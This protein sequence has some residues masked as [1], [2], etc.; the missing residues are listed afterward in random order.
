MAAKQDQVR[1]PNT[2]HGDRTAPN[3]KTR[4]ENQRVARTRRQRGYNWEDT[5]VKRFN[6]VKGWKAFRL[7]SPSVA[8]PDILAVSTV[9]NAIYTIEAKSGTSNTLHV[10]HDQIT[11]CLK[12][13]HTFEVY[14]TRKVIIAFKFLSKKRIGKGQYEHRELREYYKA[15]DETNPSTDFVCTYDGTTYSLTNGKRNR[16][17]LE[18]HGMPFDTKNKN[19]AD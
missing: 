2:A 14:Q 3:G 4:S 15:W 7:G 16:L 9:E 5:L 13:I 12:W 10:P 18:E 17:Q 19:R 11:R 1:E 6:S 8:L